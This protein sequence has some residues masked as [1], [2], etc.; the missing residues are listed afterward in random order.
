MEQPSPYSVVNVTTQVPSFISKQ[1]CSI[2]TPNPMLLLDCHCISKEYACHGRLSLASL[3]SMSS[4]LFC[5]AAC[6]LFV[7]SRARSPELPSRCYDHLLQAAFL[8]HPGSSGTF[9]S[10]PSDFWVDSTLCTLSPNSALTP[11]L[12]LSLHSALGFIEMWPFCTD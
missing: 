3:L 11:L 6:Q 4:R 7:G 1:L 12:S 5:G 9:Q 8:L 10:H 2:S